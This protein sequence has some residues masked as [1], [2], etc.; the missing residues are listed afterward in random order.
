[1]EIKRNT[2]VKVSVISLR[3]RINDAHERKRLH[4][5]DLLQTNFIGLRKSLQQSKSAE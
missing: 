3:Q 2:I 1:M 4:L 5:F